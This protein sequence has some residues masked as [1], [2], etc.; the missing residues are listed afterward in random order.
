M[1]RNEYGR[2]GLGKDS[3]DAKTPTQISSIS[4]K[5]IASV[6]AGECVSLLVTDT[7]K[8]KVLFTIS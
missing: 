2:L 7:G 1:G 4:D 5:K 6:S 3:S 8:K